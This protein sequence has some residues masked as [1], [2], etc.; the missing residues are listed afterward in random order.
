MFEIQGP[1]PGEPYQILASGV[2]VV[3]ESTWA[4][5]KGRKAL[6]VDWDKGPNASDNSESFWAD[7][8]RLL[9]GRGQVVVDDGDFDAAMAAPTRP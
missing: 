8:A 1:A 7:N 3:A 6:K 5:I 9:E 4:A 2:A